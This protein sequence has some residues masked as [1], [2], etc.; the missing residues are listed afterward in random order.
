MKLPAVE[1]VVKLAR[2]ESGLGLHFDSNNEVTRLLTG[3]AAE[4]NGGVRVGDVLLAVD[5]VKVRKGDHIGALFPMA[6]N[7]FELRL[8]RIPTSEDAEMKSMKPARPRR[9]RPGA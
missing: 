3:C 8:S 1:V 2:T 9:R 4:A 7:E 6:V 5:N